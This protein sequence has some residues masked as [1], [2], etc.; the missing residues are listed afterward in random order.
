MFKRFVGLACITAALCAA[1]LSYASAEDLPVVN[2]GATPTAVPFN[3]LNPKTNTLNGVMID[4][5]EAVGKQAHFKVNMMSVPFSSLVPALQTKKIDVIS[6]AFSKSAE[7]EKVVD[8]TQTVFS[9]GEGIVVP[10]TDKTDYKS[11]NDIKG[12]TVGVQIGVIYVE[13]LKKA[14]GADHVKMYDSMNDMISD[15]RLGRIA[16]AMGDGP[17]MSYIANEQRANGVRFVSDYKPS[18]HTTVGLAVRKGDKDRL[19]Q[20][21]E[22][23]TKLKDQGTI[24]AILKKWNITH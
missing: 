17:I 5:A 23:L 2:V 15:V 8:F 19:N 21:N 11:I 24:A 12:K 14:V 10:S 4:V 7:R 18:M 9:Y 22:A 6:S 16:V 1:P 20:L 13:P 3:F